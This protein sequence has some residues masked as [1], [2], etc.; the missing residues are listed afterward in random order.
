MMQPK[1]TRNDGFL[2]RVQAVLAND[3]VFRPLIEKVKRQGK[4][5]K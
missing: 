3:P 2:I 4:A 1:D 5:K